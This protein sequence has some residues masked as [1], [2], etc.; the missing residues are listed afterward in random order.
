MYE[1]KSRLNL[2]YHHQYQV[3]VKVKYLH[4]IH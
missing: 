2:L 4:N 1:E 3:G